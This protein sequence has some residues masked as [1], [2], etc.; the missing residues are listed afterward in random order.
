MISFFGC[1]LEQSQHVG[2]GRS[3]GE[4]VECT[5]FPCL[6]SSANSDSTMMLLREV[7]IFVVTVTSKCS[8]C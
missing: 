7:I 1:L 6:A 3:T 2:T 5:I 8:S 4:V